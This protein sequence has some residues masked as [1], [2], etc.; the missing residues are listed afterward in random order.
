VI[1]IE[2]RTSRSRSRAGVLRDT[3]RGAGRRARRGGS[4]LNRP[5]FTYIQHGR[6]FVTIKAALSLDGMVA[7]RRGARTALT[8]PEANAVVHQERAEVDA[9]AIG[10]GRCSSTTRS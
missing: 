1:A 9:I 2:D 5:F 8:G 10:R 3:R 4:A 6:P 7:A